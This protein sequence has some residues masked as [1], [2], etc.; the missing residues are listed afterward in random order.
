MKLTEIQISNGTLVD[1]WGTLQEIDALTMGLRYCTEVFG[2]NNLHKIVNKYE[3]N[4][5]LSFRVQT[6]LSDLRSKEEVVSVLESKNTRLATDELGMARAAVAA[7]TTLWEDLYH[8]CGK[9]EDRVHRL[10]LE[11]FK[12]V[13]AVIEA[14]NAAFPAPVLA[15]ITPGARNV[16]RVQDTFGMSI[17]PAGVVSALRGWLAAQPR[18][19]VSAVDALWSTAFAAL[20]KGSHPLHPGKALVPWKTLICAVRHIVSCTR[21]RSSKIFSADRAMC[22]LIDT[23]RML[24]ATHLGLGTRLSM[25][26]EAI[27]CDDTTWEMFISQLLSDG[28]AAVLLT[29]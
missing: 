11:F 25:T 28:V 14:C 18:L 1:A 15:I 20:C 10:S 23:V 27:Q 2:E 7:A 26:L 17:T 13:D 19:S 6:A 24:E 16:G 4:P 8:T 5:H 9:E 22:M 3:V 21:G 29:I 12:E